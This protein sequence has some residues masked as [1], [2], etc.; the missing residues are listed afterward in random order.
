VPVNRQA[1]KYHLSLSGEFYVAA[2][3][4][5]RGVSAAVT[6]G[7]AKKADVVAFTSGSFAVAIEVKST[8]SGRWVVGGLVPQPSIAPWV[9]VHIP[10]NSAK[11]PCFYILTESDLYAILH[12][13]DMAYRR[14][15]LAKHG[16]EYGDRKGVV[17]LTTAQA[18]P[19]KDR[20]SAILDLLHAAELKSLRTP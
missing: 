14:N 20:W 4:Q 11:S 3:L 17:N 15:F 6:F 9:F 12:P 18:E 2:E 7:N 13:I 10:S 1:E 16:E 5:R 19:F 8:A